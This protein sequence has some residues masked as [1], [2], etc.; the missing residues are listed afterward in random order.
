MNSFGL[1]ESLVLSGTYL[2]TSGRI[3]EGWVI[4]GA[5]VFFGFF[6]YTSW[7]GNNLVEKDSD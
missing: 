3:T 4:F 6:R 1:S 2:L 5:G 7:Y